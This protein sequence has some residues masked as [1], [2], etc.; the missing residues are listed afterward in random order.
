MAEDAQHSG[1]RAEVD[2]AFGQIAGLLKASMRPVRPEFVVTPG[3][4]P[5]PANGDLL[6]DLRRIGFQDVQTLLQSF[7]DQTQGV[8]DDNTLLLEHLVQLLAKL[9]ANSKVAKSLTDGFVN[10]LWSALPHPVVSSLGSQFK[11]RDAD[12]GNNNIQMPNMGRANTPYARSA[13]PTAMQN[14]ALPDPGQIFDSLMVRGDKFDPHPNGISSMLFYQATIIIHDLFRTVSITI[15][16]VI[17]DK[18]DRLGSH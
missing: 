16:P 1:F 9:P 17:C 10:Q 15:L 11:Y 5:A 3:N 4:D 2:K 12:G 13:K 14:I 6:A 7:Y 8:Q 18:T